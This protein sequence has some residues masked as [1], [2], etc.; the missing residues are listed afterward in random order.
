MNR[1]TAQLIVCHD[2]DLLQREI[3]LKKGCSASCSRCGALLYRNATDSINR[4]LAWTAAAFIVFII[5]NIFPIFAIELQ[6]DRSVLNL[7]EAVSSIW[8]QKMQL[9][10]LVVFVTTILIPTVEML[11]MIYLL[12]SL[13]MLRIP[14]GHIMIMKM[15][16]VVSPWGMI[17]ILMLGML[18][19]LVKLTSS[20]K[21]I[22]G[23]ALW[24]FGLLTFLLAAAAA[25]FSARH[26]WN[27]IDKIGGMKS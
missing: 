12:S 21:V 16:R 17:E 20:F 25:S 6:G 27:L 8:T 7:I 2:C 22:L 11:S 1:D 13:K 10:S 24:S 26:I 5:A 3:A 19:S 14:F 18:V 23:L 4:T 9:M 15:I